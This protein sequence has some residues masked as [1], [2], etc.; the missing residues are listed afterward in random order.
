MM[1]WK[2][3]L[4]SNMA[5]LG[6]YVW[7]QMCKVQETLRF[8][9]LR[10]HNVPRKNLAVI[11]AKAFPSLSTTGDIWFVPLFT[12]LYTWYNKVRSPS[13]QN[14][15]LEITAYIEVTTK[16]EAMSVDCIFHKR[17]FP[18][19]SLIQKLW[20]S[21][22]HS[23]GG[24]K[25]LFTVADNSTKGNR[26]CTQPFHKL[27]VSV[28]SWWS[29]SL[30]WVMKHLTS[31]NQ[32]YLYKPFVGGSD[33]FQ[34]KNYNR[35]ENSN[36]PSVKVVINWFLTLRSRHSWS[37]TNRWSPWDHWELFS[38]Q[39]IT[40][41]QRTTSFPEFQNKCPTKMTT[42]NIRPRVFQ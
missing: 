1:V 6:S 16:R 11:T 40:V 33:F 17:N 30:V 34:Q 23:D 35:L 39:V 4:L 36:P 22:K 9:Y 13:L 3:Y 5:I 12:C 2:M 18:A 37:V 26:C 42:T 31:K 8:R 24:T 21:N 15:P 38:Q 32:T 25:V 10:W 7:F 27:K 19:C 29:R 14:K 20:T 28:T 41:L